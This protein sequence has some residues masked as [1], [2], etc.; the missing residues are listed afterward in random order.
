MRFFDQA[1]HDL[2]NAGRFKKTWL[3]W[4]EARNG[5]VG[6]C[7]EEAARVY[8]LGDGNRTYHG[9]SGTL[10]MPN[11]R[12][13]IGL[14]A[15]SETITVAAGVP[16]VEGLLR[17]GD[18]DFAPVSADVAIH[19][20]DTGVLAGFIPIFRGFMQG[21]TWSRSFGANPTVSFNVI[22][23]LVLLD[24]T[25]DIRK[26]DEDQKKRSGDRFRQYGSIAKV[27]AE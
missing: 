18:V 27:D 2:L 10:K 15:R 4:V 13:E 23:R 25:I 5:S 26:T 20:P 14:A 16:A 17:G 11:F 21:D 7:D 22:S 6:I 12:F 24:R 9:T 3:L 1:V 8:N 19:D